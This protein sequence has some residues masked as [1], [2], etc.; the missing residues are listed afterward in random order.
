MGWEGVQLTRSNFEILNGYW[1]H[2]SNH[3]GG[4]PLRRNADDEGWGRK[5]ARPVRAGLSVLWVAKRAWQFICERSWAG[6]VG[7]GLA[8]TMTDHR[9]QGSLFAYEIAN[10]DERDQTA[11]SKQTLLCPA[12]ML[13]TS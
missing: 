4:V 2:G 10:W 1:L 3:S 7:S 12:R 6:A 13:A 11:A 8:T 9:L 5:V